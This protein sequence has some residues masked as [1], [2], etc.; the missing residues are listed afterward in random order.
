M[1]GREIAGLKGLAKLREEAAERILRTGG[2][3]GIGVMVT[4][5]TVDG[6]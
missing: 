4:M 5:V 3:R 2:L 6:G 1:S